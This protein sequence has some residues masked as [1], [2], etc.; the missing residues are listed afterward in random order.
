MK[1]EIKPAED[2]QPEDAPKIKDGFQVVSGNMF[3]HAFE[4]TVTFSPKA[5]P[6]VGTVPRKDKSKKE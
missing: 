5:A 6:P 1:Q 4:P 3:S 2:E